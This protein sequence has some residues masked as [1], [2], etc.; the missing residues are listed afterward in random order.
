MEKRVVMVAMTHWDREHARP[1]EQF[2]WHLVF[3]VVDPLLDLLE[4]GRLP[5]FTFDGQS[6]PLEDYLEIRPDRL[7]RIRDLVR[8]GRLE[9]GPFLVAPDELIPCGETLVRN[10]LLGHRVAER[11]GRATRIGHNIDAF[12]HP[13]QMPQILRGF[14]IRWAVTGRGPGE[15]VPG[16]ASPFR[17]RAPDGS[18]VVS[19]LHFVQ[20]TGDLP[21][22]DHEA[23]EALRRAVEAADPL[24]LP[25][26]LV[27]NGGDGAPPRARLADAVRAYNEAYGDTQMHI[28]RLADYFDALGEQDCG[29]WPIVSGELRSGKHNILLWG[30][31]SARCYVKLANA[32]AESA[33]LRHAEPLATAA[34]VLT[35][36]AYP[37][38]FL[39]RALRKLLENSFHDTICGCSGD[40]VYRDAMQRYAHCEQISAIITERA[41][42]RLA[43]SLSTVPPTPGGTPLLVWNPHPQEL[44]E[45]VTGVIYLAADDTGDLEYRV[46]DSEGRALPSQVVSQRVV[47]H[48]QPH[49]W[50]RFLPADKPVREIELCFTPRVPALGCAVAFLEEG[51]AE[52]AARGVW[53]DGHALE[54][55]FLRLEVLP[56][57][58]VDL[59]DKRTGHTYRGLHRFVDEES[60][61][62]EYYHVTAPTPTVVHPPAPARIAVTARGPL[63]ATIRIEYEWRLPAGATETLDG[64][65]LETVM[66]PLR[67]NV[68]LLAGVPRVEFETEFE[69]RALDHR[70]QVVFP[71]GLCSETV[72]VETPFA[73]VD[74]P[75]AL[76]PGEG[77]MDPPCPESGQQSFSSVSDG[78]VGLSVLSHGIPEIG[79]R[80]TPEGVELALTLLRAVGWIA[81]LH[82][83][84]RGYRIP[85]PEA[86]C[87]GTYRFCYA[88]YPH[89][90]DWR[91]GRAWEQAQ[92]F[93]VRPMVFDAPCSPGGATETSLIGV[94]PGELVLSAVKRAEES[95]QVVLRVWNVSPEPVSGSIRFGFPVRGAWRANLAEEAQDSL[96]VVGDA[97]GLSVRGHEILTVLV[98]PVTK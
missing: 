92:R 53:T 94:S 59:T 18:E 37:A 28:G 85:T 77:W 84:V 60:L 98:A 7:E 46:V 44:G 96:E 64:R 54:N 93:A 25:V 71:T 47:P 4:D 95:D 40:A 29:R 91:A 49:Y 83:G 81:R 63:R 22:S 75:A 78:K 48:Y 97:V 8:A 56:D 72:A 69:N 15:E 38:E 14:G 50:R 12:G 11:L 89:A 73:V 24:D 62:G 36:D 2:R 17:W 87:L 55:E 33:L 10:L 20:T 66:C 79:V 88:L 43:A 41:A 9:V 31:N 13:A 76:P 27:G 3:N 23:A 6:M 57:G 16:W 35:G 65:R 68:S 19:I 39:E 74:R 70:L 45:P 1:F 52:E 80:D 86:Q 26:L 67:V 21:A 82:W 32:R 30:V 34:W 5:C 90:G 51:R 61:C 42:K 58:S